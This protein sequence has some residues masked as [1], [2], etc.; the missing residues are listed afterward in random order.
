MPKNYETRT[1]T[2]TSKKTTAE[3]RV[4][5]KQAKARRQKRKTAGETSRTPGVASISR[6]KKKQM[7]KPKGSPQVITGN[8]ATL[9]SKYVATP[10]EITLK[11]TGL[12]SGVTKT[13]KVTVH[14]K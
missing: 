5:S 1:T 2:T 13:V 6:P 12:L 9:V 11:V 8:A 14:P 4:A 10:Q 7:G 3:T